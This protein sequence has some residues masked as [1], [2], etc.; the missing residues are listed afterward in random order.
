MVRRQWERIDKH[1]EFTQVS[2]RIRCLRAPTPANREGYVYRNQVLVS[3]DGWH[4]LKG[5]YTTEKR[6]LEEAQKHEQNLRNEL[7]GF[8]SWRL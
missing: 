2:E 1:M 8:G 5:T 4:D 3:G 7:K 6:A